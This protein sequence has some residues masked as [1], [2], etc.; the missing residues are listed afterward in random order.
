MKKLFISAAFVAASFGI[1]KA[2]NNLQLGANLG[3]TMGLSIKYSMNKVHAFEGIAGYNIKHD[4]PS[5]KFMYEYHV[6]LV[7]ALSMY[8]G[9]GIHMGGYHISKHYDGD[10][11]FG[12]VPTI[13]LQYDFSGAP[14]SFAFG[15]EPAINF[16][17]HNSWDDVA[18]KVRFRF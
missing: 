5:F 1:A 6:S 11:A 2:Q 9:G 14:V 16:T 15:Y 18:F 8:M 13:G 12:L 3:P 17:T 10:F 4:G 7:D